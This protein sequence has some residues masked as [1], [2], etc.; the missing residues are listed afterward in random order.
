MFDF[1]NL[2]DVET[3]NAIPEYLKWQGVPEYQK[4]EECSLAILAAEREE[5]Y[6]A[7]GGAH[8]VNEKLEIPR[9]PDDAF[10]PMG[11]Q[12]ELPASV[13]EHF[14]SLT[15]QVIVNF[16]VRAT[17]ARAE[18]EQKRDSQKAHIDQLHQERLAVLPKKETTGDRT[19]KAVNFNRMAFKWREVPHAMLANYVQLPDGKVLAETALSTSF[20]DKLR[21][22]VVP[23][24][25]TAMFPTG[26]IVSLV[27]NMAKSALSLPSDL[28]RNAEWH[29]ALTDVFFPEAL[30]MSSGAEVLEKK[31]PSR[32][33]IHFVAMRVAKEAGALE[34]KKLLDIVRIPRTCDFPS[35]KPK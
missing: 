34:P 18:A 30:L 9:L 32:T 24:G 23:L 19:S 2:D 6:A 27:C 31:A 21:R 20:A 17:A 4:A 28:R 5:L 13:S 11:L 29:T 3:D 25:D 7:N 16:T 35:L 15:G 33:K 8:Y 12:A 14:A 26:L 10:D 22:F 1:R